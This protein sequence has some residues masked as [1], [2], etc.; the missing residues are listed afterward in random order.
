M[1]YTEIS[2]QY[3]IDLVTFLKVYLGV[4]DPSLKQNVLRHDDLLI[5]F[6]HLTDF[7]RRVPYYYAMKNPEL[8]KDG[9]LLVVYDA[10]KQMIVYRNPGVKFNVETKDSDSR[11]QEREDV[12]LPNVKGLSKDE[13]LKLRSKLRRLHILRKD[14]FLTAEVRKRKRREPKRYR[15]EKEELRENEYIK[16]M[17]EY[18]KH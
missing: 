7:L 9:R 17:R 14:A 13:L 11:F 12:T 5:L 8:I 16:E 10:K 18:G 2:S 1:R 15:R 3:K 4:D 6:P